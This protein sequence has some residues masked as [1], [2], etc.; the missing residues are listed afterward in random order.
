MRKWIHLALAG[1]LS[2]VASAQFTPG[3][4][5]VNQVGDGTAWGSGNAAPV[6]LIEFT[7]GGTEVQR[8]AM[9]TTVNGANRRL[10]NSATATSEG[11]II[12]SLDKRFLT[13]MG[14]DADTGTLAIAGTASAAVN[15]VVAFIGA[16]E[17]IDTTTAFTDAYSGSNPRSAISTDGNKIWMSGNSSTEGGIRFATKGA[18]TSTRLHTSLPSNTR[19]VGIFNGQLYMS[20]ASGAFIGINTVGTGVPDAPDQVVTLLSGFSGV[21]NLSPYD[22]YFADENT[23][24]VADDATLVNGGGIQKWEQSGGVWSRTY[25]LQTGITAGCRGL[26][27]VTSSGVTTLYATT[28]ENPTR[29]VVVTDLGSTS[30]FTALATAVTNTAFRGVDFAPEAGSTTE[31]VFPSSYTVTRGVEVGGNDVTKLLTNDDVYAVVQ[32]RFQFAPTLPNTE[33]IAAMTVPAGN[34]ITDATLSVRVKANSLPFSDS[35]CKQD[36]AL[37]DRSTGQFVVV[38]SRK[39]QNPTSDEPEITVA[40]DASQRARF[41]G[42]DGLVDVSIRVFHLTPLLGG[43][44]M[45]TDLVKLTVTR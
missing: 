28:A 7:P 4:L 11:F 6:F 37:R 8:V 38:D 40:L 13:S 17:S 43:W 25:V 32:Q 35:S 39:P 27:A 5:V 1:A 30:P 18:T 29:L 41:I 45:S 26:T 9:P 33:L 24:Y 16:D 15:R 31:D 3:N 12:R 34:P 20:S 42:N 23:L 22:F 2:A 44:T 36:I 19:V 21:A 10:V 14:Y